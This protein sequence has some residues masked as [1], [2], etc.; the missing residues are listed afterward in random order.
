VEDILWEPLS[1]TARGALV[2]RLLMLAADAGAAYAVVPQ[3][4]YADLR[5][6]L[7]AG[8]LPAPHTQNA[9]LTLW[10]DPDALPA[11]DSFYLDVV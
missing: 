10:S 7:A 4:G 8:F 1:Q 2:A 5:P 6:F 3:L 9:N 11:A